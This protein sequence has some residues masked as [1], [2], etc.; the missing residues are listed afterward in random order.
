MHFNSYWYW[1][2]AFFSLILLI[3]I[4]LKRGVRNTL[5]LFLAIVECTYLIEAVIY[6]FLGCYQYYPM[7]IKNNSYYDSHMGAIMSN[8]F[9][10]PVLAA[11]IAVFR[12]KFSWILLIIALLAGIEWLFLKLG[13]YTQYWWRTYYTTLG[14]LIYFPFSKI[15]YKQILKPLKNFKHSLFLFLCISPILGTMH[16]LP[17][18]LF[19]SRSYIIGWFKD[20]SYD[21]S[22][23]AVIYYILNAI[24]QVILVKIHWN[25][26]LTKYILM[27]TILFTETYILKRLGILQSFVWWDQWLYILFPTVI[28]RL[29]N[30]ASKKLATGPL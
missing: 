17:F 5:L 2:L 6:I 11:L 25:N 15:V 30:Y 28:L 16:F 27:L 22:A 26:S 9:T 18:M 1:A 24:L 13:I 19:S 21:T 10:I 23:F 8:L 29:T 7:I 12:L 20:P 14:L 3:F 4:C